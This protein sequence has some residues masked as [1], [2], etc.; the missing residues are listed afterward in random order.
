M[1]APRRIDDDLLRKLWR[2]GVPSRAIAARFGVNYPAVN[3]AAAR[4][5]LPKRAMRA[6]AAAGDGISDGDLLA[7]LDARDAGLSAAETARR[8]GGLT[9]GAVR[10]VWERV[11]ADCARHPC[12][13]TRPENRDGGMPARW[14]ADGLARQEG[15]R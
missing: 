11:D 2:E 5:G 9:A 1:T 8:I 6:A 3:R 14:W 10:D 7:L 4:L 15:R 13:A 12:M